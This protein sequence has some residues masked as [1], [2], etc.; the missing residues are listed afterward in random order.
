MFGDVVGAEDFCQVT[1]DGSWVL[2]RCESC[3]CDEV[4]HPIVVEPGCDGGGVADGVSKI[5]DFK[6]SVAEG[7]VVNAACHQW[8][9]VFGGGS[10]V[11]DGVGFGGVCHHGC[12][13]NVVG[14]DG[15][16]AVGDVF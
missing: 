14:G 7:A 6:N 2:K 13:A 11:G 16:F 9:G 5:A 15:S 12:G 4:F 8:H 1:F 10:P 3:L